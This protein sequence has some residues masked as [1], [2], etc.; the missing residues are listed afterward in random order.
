MVRLQIPCEELLPSYLEFIDEMRALGEKIWDGFIPRE[1]ESELEF[2][3]RLVRAATAPE[4]PKVAETTYWACV[5]DRVV[6]RIALRHQ[7]NDDLKEF[8]G[9]VGYEVRPSFRNQGA[10]KEMLKQLLQTPK[11][12]EVGRLL[13]TCA[14]DNIASNKTIIANGGILAKTAY[15]QKWQRDTNYYWIDVRAGLV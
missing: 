7:L 6:G 15:V 14:P 8:G 2:V 13:F 4:Q 12:R 9:H 11:A 5:G 1:G 3:L 10:A